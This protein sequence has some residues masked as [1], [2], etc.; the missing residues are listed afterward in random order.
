MTGALI[1]ENKIYRDLRLKWTENKL[2]LT[3]FYTRL[4]V[5]MKNQIQI[6]IK[7][8]LIYKQYKL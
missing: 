7:F 4:P 2:F 5:L 8:R 3:V 6:T 1:S